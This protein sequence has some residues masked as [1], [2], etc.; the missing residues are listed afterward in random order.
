V[1]GNEYGLVAP[2]GTC[3]AILRAARPNGETAG[4]VGRDST[5]SLC[6][7]QERGLRGR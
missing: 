5:L 3:R 6:G 4:A 2:S 1:L 7:C